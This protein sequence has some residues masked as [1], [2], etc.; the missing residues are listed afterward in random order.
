ME[1][2][3]T[4]TA[5]RFRPE[6]LARAKNRARS[7]GKTLNAFIEG[8]LE[9]ELGTKEERLEQIISEIRAMRGTPAHK[10]EESFYDMVGCIEG[11]TYSQE[12]L[13][14]D[15]KLAYLVDKYGL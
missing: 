7:E 2:R 11:I 5:F 9:K 3:S 14:A 4:Q 1:T 13:N 8:I 12:E 10:L 6:L 15:P